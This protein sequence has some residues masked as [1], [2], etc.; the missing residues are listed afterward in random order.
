MSGALVHV[1]HG[2]Y[3]IVVK[4][5]GFVTKSEPIKKSEAVKMLTRLT[6]TGKE[7]RPCA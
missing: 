7:K 6:F 5:F 1:G 3:V 4:G 2:Q